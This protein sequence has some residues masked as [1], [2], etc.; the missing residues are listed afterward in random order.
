MGP[1]RPD[2]ARR[3]ECRHVVSAVIDRVAHAIDQA[4]NYSFRVADAI[5]TWDDAHR[6]AFF[7]WCQLPFSP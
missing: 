5:R 7:A 4:R 3:R 6:D 2:A 1:L